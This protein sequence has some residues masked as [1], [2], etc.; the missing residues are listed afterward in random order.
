[1]KLCCIVVL[2]LSVALPAQAQEQI[3][4]APKPRPSFAKATEGGLI[5]SEQAIA[6]ALAEHPPAQPRRPRDSVANGMLIGG[7]LVG[8][9]VAATGGWVCHM[10]KEPD[11]PSCWPGIARVG[12]IGFGIGAALGAGIDLLVSRS[13]ASAFEGWPQMTRNSWG[14]PPMKR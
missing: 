10:L 2:A 4:E 12:A 9:G 5:I 7:L 3:A 11:D 8:I 6:A 14:Q 13:P 1:M